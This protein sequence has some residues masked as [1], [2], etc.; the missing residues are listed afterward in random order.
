MTF[1]RSLD[2]KR[3]VVK[4]L[5]RSLEKF[6]CLV[7]PRINRGYQARSLQARVQNDSEAQVWSVELS[8]ERRDG[9]VGGDVA[10]KAVRTEMVYV[11]GRL[12]GRSR[13]LRVASRI[14][15][16]LSVVGTNLDHEH[17]GEPTVA[18]IRKLIT[19]PNTAVQMR[20]NSTHIFSENATYHSGGLC[21]RCALFIWKSLLSLSVGLS[22]CSSVL[23]SKEVSNSPDASY[24]SDE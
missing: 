4:V 23:P 2:P 17:A 16:I 22:V 5:R 20:R 18:R 21:S 19:E 13:S 1:N 9:V 14:W 6:T 15:K 24:R 12:A 11:R 3:R 8:I 10:L 7:C